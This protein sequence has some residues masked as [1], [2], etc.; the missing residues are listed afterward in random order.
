[1]GAPFKLEQSSACFHR[2]AFLHHDANNKS[3][4]ITAATKG[5]R[6]NVARRLLNKTNNISDLK[7]SIWP[8]LERFHDPSFIQTEVTARRLAVPF[9]C[10]EENSSLTKQC[11]KRLLNNL[12]QQT[13][14]TSDNC[15]NKHKSLKNLRPLSSLSSSSGILRPSQLSFIILLF[16]KGFVME[17]LGLKRQKQQKVVEVQKEVRKKKKKKKMIEKWKDVKL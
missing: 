12:F 16:V 10:C 9:H 15:R 4:A 2:H 5:N 11:L 13:K 8:Y 3:I 17:E 7:Q 14:S 1:M 6:N